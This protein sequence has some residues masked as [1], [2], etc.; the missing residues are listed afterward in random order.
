[1]ASKCPSSRVTGDVPG[2]Q[3]H[4]YG[5]RVY[6]EMRLVNSAIIGG[7]SG[8][9]RRNIYVCPACGEALEPA[10]LQQ[11]AGIGGGTYCPKCGERVYVSSPY[12]KL[13][14]VLS[15]LPAVGI[16]LLMH[17]TSVIW[18]MAG[19]LVLWVPISLFLNLYS[20]Q[21]TRSTLKKWQPRK[22]RTFFEW[23]YERDQI[24]APEI[25]DKDKKDF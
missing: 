13:V 20:T 4:M 25:F 8:E 9:I 12:P 24:R 15:L 11:P 14:A 18:F 5:F 17:V 23:L 10:E 16:L 1:M 6:Q 21:F 2:H 22:R 3:F 7:V 19:T